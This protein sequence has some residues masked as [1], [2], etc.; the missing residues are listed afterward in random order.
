[1]IRDNC[2][3]HEREREMNQQ[4]RKN[5]QENIFKKRQKKNFKGLPWKEGGPRKI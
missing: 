1:M 4:G 5:N 2:A 3:L